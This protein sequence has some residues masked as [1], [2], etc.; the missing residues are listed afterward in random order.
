M[1]KRFLGGIPFTTHE[2]QIAPP[3]FFY[4]FFFLVFILILVYVRLSYDFVC[5]AGLEPPAGARI[6]RNEK[7]NIRGGGGYVLQEQSQD[8]PD[9]CIT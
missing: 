7:L 4:L 6:R 9:F 8:Y 1:I 2:A 5:P 3:P